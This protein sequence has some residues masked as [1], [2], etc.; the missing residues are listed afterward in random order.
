[1]RLAGRLIIFSPCDDIPFPQFAPRSAYG[2]FFILSLDT[3][4]QKVCK[5]LP[6][7]FDLE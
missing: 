3:R 6:L 1:M 7:Y 4:T 5:F 2:I